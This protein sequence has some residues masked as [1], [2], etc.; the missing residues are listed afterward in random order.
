[1]PEWYMDELKR[2]ERQWRKEKLFCKKWL[3]GQTVPVPWWKRCYV[4]PEYRN[5][6]M[7]KI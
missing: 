6:K 2:F 3:G 5:R 1:M 4:L 7:V